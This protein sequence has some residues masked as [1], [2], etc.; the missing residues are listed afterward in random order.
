M[1]FTLHFLRP[2]K[3][4][5]SYFVSQ[6]AVDNYSWLLTTSYFVL[7]IAA[8]LMLT[9]LL[10]NIDTSKT[11]KLMLGMFCFGMVLAAIFPTDVPVTSPTPIGLIHALAA[12]TALISLGI[13]MIAWGFVFR[14]NN[15][16]K[17]LATP[18]IF[19]GV[20]S[21]VLFIVHFVSP[22]SIK[23]LTQRILLV[24]DIS[25]LLLVSW[26]LYRNALLPALQLPGSVSPGARMRL[27]Q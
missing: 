18:S 25:W 16:L 20:L 27:E 15:N 14:K 21:L 13:S 5:L 12:L 19:F 9:G 8:A 24:W 26:K 6:Y 11:S 2:D 3:N 23:G 22:V 1:V 7:A 10:L 17:S 4:M